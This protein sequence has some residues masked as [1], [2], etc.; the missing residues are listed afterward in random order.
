LSTQNGSPEVTVEAG[1]L[2]S[3]PVRLVAQRD[4]EGERNTAVAFTVETEGKPRFRV[5]QESR[6]MLPKRTAGGR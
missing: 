3:V 6:F 2:A 4:V 5:T 1:A